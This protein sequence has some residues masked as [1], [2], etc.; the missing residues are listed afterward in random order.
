MSPLI[1]NVP[2]IFPFKLRVPKV[3]KLLGLLLPWQFFPVACKTWW[4]RTTRNRHRFIHAGN[5]KITRVITTLSN[6]HIAVSAGITNVTNATEV[7]NLIETNNECLKISCGNGL[8]IM[9]N[10]SKVKLCT[11]VSSARTLGGFYER[12]NWKTRKACFA[13]TFKTIDSIGAWA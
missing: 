3:F 11:A 2:S 5:T 12:T 9:T 13:S 8:W 10:T 1:S 7:V 6:N 4:T